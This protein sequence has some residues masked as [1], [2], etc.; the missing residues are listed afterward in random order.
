[1]STTEMSVVAHICGSSYTRNVNRSIAVQ[2]G[3]G[4]NERTYAE[5]ENC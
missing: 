5:K 4:K 3:L 1:M 2:A